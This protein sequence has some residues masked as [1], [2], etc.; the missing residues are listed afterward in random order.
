MMWAATTMLSSHHEN[1]CERAIAIIPRSW[2]VLAIPSSP[3]CTRGTRTVLKGQISIILFVAASDFRTHPYRMN[4][5]NEDSQKL[6]QGLHRKATSVAPH[7]PF[8]CSYPSSSTDFASDDLPFGSDLLEACA[9]SLVIFRIAIAA[10]I[11]SSSAC[12]AVQE[13]G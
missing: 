12:E 4:K 6:L 13:L 1:W 9:F 8:L 10:F 11:L 3:V 2:H 7:V 5:A